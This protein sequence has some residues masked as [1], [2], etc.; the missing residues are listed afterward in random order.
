MLG[1]SPGLQKKQEQQCG[2]QGNL[3][4]DLSLG[5]FQIGLLPNKMFWS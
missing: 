5:E 2:E 3:D 4:A 1:R